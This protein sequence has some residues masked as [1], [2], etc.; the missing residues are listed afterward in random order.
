MSV[1]VGVNSLSVVHASS[2]QVPLSAFAE[3]IRTTAPLAI[4]HQE[5]FPS[6][7]MSFNLAPGAARGDAVKKKASAERVIGNPQS[8]IGSN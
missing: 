6:V 5:Q 1:T 2:T 7:T 3:L 4:A 8:V